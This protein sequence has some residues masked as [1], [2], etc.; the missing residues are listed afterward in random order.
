MPAPA[1]I[2]GGPG[3]AH[4]RSFPRCQTVAD[5]LAGRGMSCRFASLLPGCLLPGPTDLVK[6]LLRQARKDTTVLL[7]LSSWPASYVSRKKGN[8]R[9]G[10]PGRR[11]TTFRCLQWSH[12]ANSSTSYGNE[13]GNDRNRC[14]RWK[15]T[16]VQGDGR[17]AEVRWEN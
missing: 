10:E 17:W 15:A 3:P 4:P 11:L 14:A 16:V 1:L 8:W 7:L 9:P 13:N 6:P 12:P 2:R 5:R